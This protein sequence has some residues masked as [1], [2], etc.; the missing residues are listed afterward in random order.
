M[1]KHGYPDTLEPR[2]PLPEDVRTDGKDDAAKFLWDEI[3]QP[4]RWPMPLSDIADESGWSRQH[5][6]NTIQTYFEEPE[7]ETNT[8]RVATGE[9]TLERAALTIP[10]NVDR[11]SYLRGYVDCLRN[12]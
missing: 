7:E 4:G 9:E 10:E 5:I 11:Q 12:E 8:V 2:E 6:S 1:P 3:I